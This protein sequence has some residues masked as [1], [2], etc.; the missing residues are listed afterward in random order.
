MNN[1]K[2]KIQ[3]KSFSM[4]KRI[5]TRSESFSD[6]GDCVAKCIDS[7]YTDNGWMSVILFVQQLI[8]LV[9]LLVLHYGALRHVMK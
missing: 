1:E 3:T 2:K 4:Q 6:K 7:V 8:V 5:V 9:L